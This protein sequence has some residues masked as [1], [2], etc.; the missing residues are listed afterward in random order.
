[1]H[2]QICTSVYSGR[3]IEGVVKKY[4]TDSIANS[5]RMLTVNNESGAI[6]KVWILVEH[7]T[8]KDIQ[9]NF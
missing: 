8:F 3:R 7:Q 4:T 5:Q 1:M 9:N 6:T 2:C